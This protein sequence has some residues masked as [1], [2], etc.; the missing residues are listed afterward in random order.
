[1]NGQHLRALPSDKLIKILGERWKT[2]G[3]LLESEGTFV[4]VKELLFDV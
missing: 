2:T 4:E 3:I 1:M